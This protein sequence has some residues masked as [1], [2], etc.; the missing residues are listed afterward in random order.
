MFSEPITIT[1]NGVGKSLNKVS[2]I[3]QGNTN[4]A[5]YQS[6]DENWKLTISHQ[7]LKDKIRTLTKFEQRVI[8]ADPLTAEN[9]YMTLTE[10]HVTDR[11][12]TGFAQID[13]ERHIAGFNDWQKLNAT[14]IKLYG[15]ES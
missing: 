8:A 9:A 1:V 2:T 11:P 10:Q 13:V 6:S 15:Q 14:Q 5:V 3:S 12:I 4:G 7:R